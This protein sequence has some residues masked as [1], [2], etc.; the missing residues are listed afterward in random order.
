MTMHPWKKAVLAASMALVMS[1]LPRPCAAEAP[2]VH[3]GL[4]FRFGAGAGWIHDSGEVD[5]KNGVYVKGTITGESLIAALALGGAVSS[6][7]SLGGSCFGYLL[8]APHATHAYAR[9][10]GYTAHINVDFDSSALLLLGPFVDFY[11]NPAGGFHLFASAGLAYGALGGA[12][13]ILGDLRRAVPSESGG[14]VGGLG[15]LGYDLWISRAWTLGLF[16]QV[17]LAS[18]AAT[19][20]YD[21]RTY[22]FIV[23]PALLV[24]GAYESH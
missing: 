16:G 23:V 10:Y 8:P 22:H 6:G 9:G 14:G 19:D 21:N 2:R 12:T 24:T 15:A 7:T 4:Y 1:T 17:G 3:D 20:S 13:A 11:P 5:E 18:I